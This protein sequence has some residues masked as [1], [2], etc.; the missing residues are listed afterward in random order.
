MLALHIIKCDLT[1]TSA[2]TKSPVGT[3]GAGHARCNGK[4]LPF[5][6][7]RPG[8]LVFYPKDNLCQRMYQSTHHVCFR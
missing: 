2:S 5:A 7:P 8:Q 3:E 6:S 1:K 4:T